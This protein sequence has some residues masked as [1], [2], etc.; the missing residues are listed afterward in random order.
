ME[1][2]TRKTV[3]KMNR[4]LY[5]IMEKRRKNVE[6]VETKSTSYDL[7]LNDSMLRKKKY[8]ISALEKNINNLSTKTL[9]YTQNLT[10]EFCVKYILNYEHSSCVED[11]YICIGDVLSAQ[12]HITLA[13]IDAA[14]RSNYSFVV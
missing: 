9:L 11:T 12:K 2:I 1:K 3:E 7:L 10:A 13:D 14:Y 8:D 5:D 4:Q 6:P